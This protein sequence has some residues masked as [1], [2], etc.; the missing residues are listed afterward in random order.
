MTVKLKI[1]GRVQG[2]F[3]R[4]TA[5]VE[6]DKLGLVGWVRNIQSH[7]V[8]ADA[9]GL[10]D[11]GSVEALAVGPK[12]KIEKFIAWC[13]KGPPAAEVKKVEIEWLDSSQEYGDFSIK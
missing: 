9:A 12:E 2:V 4:Q 8:L 10:D 6:A 11:D 13:K 3:F 5:K 1:Y 7:A